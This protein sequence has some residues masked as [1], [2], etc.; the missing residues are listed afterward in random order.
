LAIN[1][2]ELELAELRYAQLYSGD[3]AACVSPL[4][5]GIAAV[6]DGDS[7]KF[8]ITSARRMEDYLLAFQRREIGVVPNRKSNLIACG[9]L[10]LR[11]LNRRL[12]FLAYSRLSLVN[13]VYSAL[14]GLDNCLVRPRLDGINRIY[15]LVC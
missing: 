14:D 10:E 15:R 6:L 7:T 2:N 11:V 1:L 5:C 9:V 3:L 12:S 13:L 4:G 8:S